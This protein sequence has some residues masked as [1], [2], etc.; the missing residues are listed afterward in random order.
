MKVKG[1]QG[2]DFIDKVN[3]VEL[4]RMDFRKKR[5]SEIRICL[6]FKVRGGEHKEEK[7]FLQI[8]SNVDRYR[9]FSNLK[10]GPNYPS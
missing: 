9:S 1:L 2:C 6:S 4:K 5:L 8:S 3:L 7:E 10:N